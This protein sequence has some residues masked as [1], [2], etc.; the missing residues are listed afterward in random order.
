MISYMRQVAICN[1]VREKIKQT[2]A[3]SND[4]GIRTKIINIPTTESVLRAV[5][6]F[7]NIDTEEELKDFITKHLLSSLRLTTVQQEHP[8]VNS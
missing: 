6:L 7:P 1:A 8:N 3:R 4:M 2:L 5:S